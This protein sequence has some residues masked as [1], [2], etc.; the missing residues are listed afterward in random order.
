M[1]SV[2]LHYQFSELNLKRKDCSLD[3][4]MIIFQCSNKI[5]FYD[6]VLEKCR[7]IVE[8]NSKRICI[9]DKQYI[10]IGC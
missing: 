8:K 1:D 7:Q 6:Y 9:I 3:K 10:A 5:Y 4:Q 2:S